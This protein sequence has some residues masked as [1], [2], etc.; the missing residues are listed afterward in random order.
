MSQAG[1]TSQD[2]LA[3]LMASLS[4]PAC[5][6]M[7]PA[8]GIVALML[9]MPLQMHSSEMASSWVLFSWDE[10]VPQAGGFSVKLQIVDVIN[11]RFYCCFI[12][13]PLGNLLLVSRLSYVISLG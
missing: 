11:I 13:S 12:S 4:S 5:D 1:R 7:P 10:W 8:I 9:S 2:P 3:M 6:E